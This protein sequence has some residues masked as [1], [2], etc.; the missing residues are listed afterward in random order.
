MP[1]VQY[2]ATTTGLSTTAGYLFYLPDRDIRPFA[3]GIS[4]VINST[5]VSYNVEYT[6]D[7][8]GIFSGTGT[9]VSSAHNW[10]PDSIINGASS[11]AYTVCTIPNSG[12]R[13]NVTSG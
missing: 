7:K 13:L 12:I 9:F 10:F 6:F 11:N 8:L 4:C 3:L 5:T 2:S 1:S